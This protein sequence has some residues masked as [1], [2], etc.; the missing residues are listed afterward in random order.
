MLKKISFLL[1][2]FCVMAGIAM[3]QTRTITGEVYSAA[4][5]SPLLGATVSVKGATANA[6]TDIDGKFS[7]TIP[8][9]SKTLIVSYI[10]ME[11]K[12]VTIK[13]N[14]IRIYLDDDTNL[15]EEV[16]VMG[17][18]SARRVG[19]VTGA[20]AK[21]SSDKIANNPTSDFTDALQGQVAGLSVMNQSGE[22]TASAVIRLRGT[23]SINAG[24]SP[25][26]VLDGVPISEDF[27]NALNPS[28]IENITVL[29]DA[30][31]TAIYGSRASNGVILITSKKGRTEQRPAIS[32]NFQ[33]GFAN[34]IDNGTKMMNAEQ[35]MAFRE[36]LN[37]ALLSD[38]QWMKHKDN[39]KALGIDTDWKKET[40]HNNAPTLQVNASLSGGTSNTDYYISI[41]HLDR[42]GI[43]PMSKFSRQAVRFTENIRIAPTF[44]VGVDLNMSYR[45]SQSNPEQ[46][47]AG[48]YM[49]NPTVFSRLARP[50]DAPYYYNIDT[51][52][53]GGKADYLHYTKNN[54]YTPEWLANQRKRS[55]KTASVNATIFE[56]WKP[57]TGLTLKAVQ[58]VNG[59]DD[60]YTSILYP[61]KPYTSIMGDLVSLY[62]DGS[63]PNR[64]ERSDRYYQF[65]AQN[66]AEYTFDINGGH[67]LYFLAGH[68]SVMNKYDV[69]S[70]Y[71][72]GLSD[73]RMMMLGNSAEEP[74]VGQSLAEYA[75]NSF[76]AKAEYGF[77][78]KYIFNASVRTDGSSRFPAGH[79]WGTFWSVGG[80]WNITREAFM[81]QTKSWLNQLDL[82]A[83]YGI[84]GNEEIGEYMYQGLV[85]SSNIRYE[86]SGQ[87]P[88]SGIV[89]TS[90]N[91]P[92]LTWEVQKK[93][94]VG[95]EMR[96]FDRVQIDAEYF[97]NTTKDMLFEI[98]YSFTT[99]Y[100]TGWGNVGSM[101]NTGVE[102]SF[103]VDLIKS[104]DINWT[105]GANITYVNNKMVALYNDV[106]EFT[107][108]GTG[109]RY[110][111]GH[112]W[113]ELYLVKRAG[114][115][116]RDGKQM[117]YDRDGN[118][119]KEYNYDSMAQFTGKTASAPWYGG[120]N[121][122]FS[123]KGLTL[124]A[125][126]NWN[127]G[128]YTLN[129]DRNFCENA[130]MLDYNQFVTMEN[131][132]TTPGQITDIPKYGETI[133]MDDHI[134]ENSSFLRL[135]KLTIGYNLPA[136]L[137]NPLKVVKNLYIY[138]SGRNLFTLTQY[139]GY[140]PEPGGN[141]ISFNYPNTRE[142][143]F[144]IQVSF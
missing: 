15:M 8:Q 41:S 125:D 71:R 19:S 87:S 134:L 75:R 112:A 118:I 108:T 81:K 102:L 52:E 144:G 77:M 83:S 85:S 39:V 99:G 49:T 128:K 60:R 10:G 29:K 33:Y 120:F 58:S 21:V 7:I 124:S 69:I 100:S 38:A 56:E 65:T 126:F 20:V 84:T 36:K 143:T 131:V 46:N 78:Q 24:V 68:E 17:Y 28:D 63:T 45:D 6:V 14:K 61:D 27:F 104:K 9:N 44:K 50:D 140:D 142:Y 74:T 123:W 11:T 115:D 137:L 48:L 90:Q 35:Y 54:A 80:R 97:Y 26:F 40:Y 31:S 3:A 121:T 119:T 116:P 96:L 51:R 130:N 138:A 73:I 23:N 105:F 47:A 114:V 98:P 43:E 4:D 22:P 109:F 79:R 117:W 18:G 132:W 66:T 37:P 141:A 30:Q 70:I 16:V 133:Q 89:V 62:S 107:L 57:V 12:E 103:N 82:R 95:L 113:D 94:N 127:L 122:N 110:A 139:T 76:F 101:R 136:R 92:N 67:N 34:V 42:E 64:T 53:I 135:K 106:E 1:T 91:I 25:L 88:V 13:N 5:S 93:F 32:I 59:Y 2:L 129:N 111:I 86:N 72:D 55:S